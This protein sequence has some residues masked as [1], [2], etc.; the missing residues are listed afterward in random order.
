[1]Q[2]VTNWS[3]NSHG[4]S[5]DPDGQNNL[6]TQVGGL[7]LPDFKTYYKATVIETVLHCHE[8]RTPL[9]IIYEH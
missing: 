7:T 8:V 4:N 9:H 1:M 2:I 3:E 6:E 5:L